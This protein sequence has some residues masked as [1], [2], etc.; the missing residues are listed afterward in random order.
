V[1]QKTSAL[2]LLEVRAQSFLVPGTSHPAA[3]SLTVDTLPKSLPI[4]DDKG[5]GGK[6]GRGKKDKQASKRRLDGAAGKGSGKSPRAL[7]LH[8]EADKKEFL[9]PSDVEIGKLLKED[10]VRIRIR[11]T[12][13]DITIGKVTYQKQDLAD[14]ANCGP[15][16]KCWAVGLSN[17]PWPLKLHLCNHSEEPSHAA[18]DSPAHLFSKEQVSAL[19]NIREAADK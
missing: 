13:N 18:H 7:G 10:P 4:A 19:R 5:K 6:G 12:E 8:W 17:K 16:D 14:A 9:Q 3:G 1:Q 2:H 11:E 15:Y